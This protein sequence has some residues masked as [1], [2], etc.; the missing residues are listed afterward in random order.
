MA[1]RR[2]KRKSS[3]IKTAGFAAFGLLIIGL[4]WLA[5]NTPPQ[6]YIPPTI[7]SHSQ[8]RTFSTQTPA[9][10]RTLAADFTLT[11]ID[12]RIFRLSD[13]RGKV[14]VLEFMY[15]TCPACVAESPILKDL[16]TRFGGNV[17]MVMISIDPDVDTDN[18]LRDYRDQNM[19]GWI[20]IRDKAQVHQLYAV[21]ATPT[22]LLIDSNGYVRYSHVGVTESSIL[23][24]E[25]ETLA[26]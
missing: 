14:V 6:V 21:R 10:S 8:P 5:F 18:V 2:R 4:V 3:M 7:T 20:A 23:I 11:D 16:R 25:V 24:A 19:M 13:Q 26:T 9:S 17:V 12:G 15:T 22:I 1:R